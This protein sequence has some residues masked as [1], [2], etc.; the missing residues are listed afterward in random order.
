MQ[1]PKAHL[2]TQ[3]TWRAITWN[4]RD[5]HASNMYTSDIFVMDVMLNQDSFH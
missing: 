5:K 2:V 1:K 4:D 3:M